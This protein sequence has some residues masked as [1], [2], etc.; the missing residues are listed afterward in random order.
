M[1][2]AKWA[3]GGVVALSL[4]GACRL[5]DEKAPRPVANEIDHGT[6]GKPED[7]KNPGPTPTQASEETGPRQPVAFAGGTFRY[8]YP[9]IEPGRHPSSC[10]QNVVFQLQV[11]SEAQLI[12]RLRYRAVAHDFDGCSEPADLVR[13]HLL[14]ASKGY[15]LTEPLGF[16]SAEGKCHRRIVEAKALCI[17]E[18]ANF[19]EYRSF[20]SEGI[21]NVATLVQDGDVEPLWGEYVWDRVRDLRNLQLRLHKSGSVGSLTCQAYVYYSLAGNRRVDQDTCRLAPDWRTNFSLTKA[22]SELICADLFRSLTNAE[23]GDVARV[24]VKCVDAANR[25]YLY[26]IRNRR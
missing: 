3:W 2:Q 4:L 8:Q 22:D 1:R 10:P 26:E 11:E 5:K 20:E 14:E 17:P 12:C 19:M 24:T 25:S 18:S 23:V 21:Q 16:W 9:C 15:R 13:S 6:S 7:K